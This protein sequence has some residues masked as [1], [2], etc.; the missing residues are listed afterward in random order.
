MDYKTAGV[1]IEAGNAFVERL[2]EKAPT[3]GGFGGMFKVPR[4][5][6][7][8]ILVSGADGVGTKLK[9]AQLECGGPDKSAMHGIGLDL[10][11]MCVNDVI[12]CGAK[13]LY[14]LDYICT[15]DLKLY[16]NLVKHLVDGI[17]EGCK[18]SGC[19]L[20]GGETAEHPRRMGSA[21]SIRDVSGFCTGIIEE[22][23]IIN[24]SLIH[25]RDVIIGIESSGIHS[26]GYSLINEMLWRHKISYK[27]SHIGEGTPELLTPTT[28]YVSVVEALLKEVPILGMAHITGGGIPE[29]LPRCLPKGLKAHVDYNSWPLPKL[30]S[31]IQLAGEIPEEDMK[32]TFNMGIGYCLVIPDEGVQDAHDVIASYGYK[33]WTI[34]E[35]VV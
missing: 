32:T 33:S 16:G 18:I 8:P 14:F 26:N 6:E 11:A 4:G 30:F 23:E 13:P 25:E 12:T 7:E 2:K 34:G 19:S 22:N 24:G 28:I 9:I 21:P 31:K 5:Y 15:S 35:I 27:D 29:N 1:D 10:V 3:I 20:L 17:V